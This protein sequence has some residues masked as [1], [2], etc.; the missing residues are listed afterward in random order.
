MS[1]NI[2][3]CHYLPWLYLK[4]VIVLKSATSWG[5]QMSRVPTS[6]SGRSGNPKVAG[7]SQE[8]AVV[9]P[10]LS[11]TNDFKIDTCHSIAW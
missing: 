8:L 9:E 1:Y 5:G 4:R 6:P 3:R 10:W 11:Q 2:D 7:S